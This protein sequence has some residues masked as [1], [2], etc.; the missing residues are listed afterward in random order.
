MRVVTKPYA[1]LNFV[2][3]KVGECFKYDGE[4][5]IRT[6]ADIT[7]A[8]VLKTGKCARFSD[9]CRVERVNAEVREV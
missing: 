8:V 7:N 6:D 3:L 2:G 1:E 4:L 5:Y 9:G